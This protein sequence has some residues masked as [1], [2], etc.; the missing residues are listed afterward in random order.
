MLNYA[1]ALNEYSGPVTAVSTQL[2]NLRKRA[3]ITAGSD[4]R[5]G[6]PATLTKDQMRELIKNERRIEMAFEEQ[7]Y[8]DVRRWK[9][10]EQAFSKQVRGVTITQPAP[11]VFSYQPMPVNTM[12]FLPKMYL[13][14]LPAGELM[15][16]TN[17][18]QNYGW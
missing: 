6:I 1:E 11:G 3:G 2:I 9:T 13:Y 15:K 12:V 10:A 5:Y 4:N 7:R 17:L 18:I 16:N 8:W 14:P